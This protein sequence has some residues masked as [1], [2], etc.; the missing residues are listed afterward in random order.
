MGSIDLAA[1]GEEN[2]NNVILKEHHEQVSVKHKKREFKEKTFVVR[3]SL[4]T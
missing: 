1:K 3:E 4:L 2:N